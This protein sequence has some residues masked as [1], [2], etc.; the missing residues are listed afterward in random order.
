VGALCLGLGLGCGD[1]APQEGRAVA[2]EP[3]PAA[4]AGR[5]RHVIESNA[6]ASVGDL[7]IGVGNCWERTYEDREGEEHTGLTCGL[8]IAVEDHPE[9]FEHVV[10]HSGLE[11]DKEGIHLTVVAVA[12]DGVVIDSEPARAP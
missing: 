11:L 12:T 9:A 3:A 4:V 8:W 6:Q 7:R 10:A 2:L 1:D 5:E